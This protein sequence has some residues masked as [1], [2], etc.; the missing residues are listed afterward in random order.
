MKKLLIVFVFLSMLFSYKSD[1]RPQ[2]YPFTLKN[3]LGHNVSLSDFKGKVVYIDVWATWCKSCIEQIPYSKKLIENYSQND[4]IVFINISIDDDILAWQNFIR[5]KGMKGINLHSEGGVEEKIVERYGIS[6]IPHYI[7]I[8]KEGRVY[9]N[10][11]T[12]PSDSTTKLQLDAL[13]KE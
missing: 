1:Y 2:A 3:A 8:D 5:K 6:F 12:H 11:A 9:K 10:G 13:L 7:M 4:S